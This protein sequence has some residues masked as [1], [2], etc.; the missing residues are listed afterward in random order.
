MLDLILT[1]IPG[2]WLAAVGLAIA[3]LAATW[4]G[5]RKAGKTDANVDALKSEVKAHERMSD[6]DLGHGASDSERIK[7]LHDF[8][9]RHGG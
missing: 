5:G 1:I 8:A 2:E 6:A 9:G 3:A 7:R 4:F